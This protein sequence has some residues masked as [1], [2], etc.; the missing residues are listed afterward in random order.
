[1]TEPSPARAI[2]DATP[3]AVAWL[4]A[5]AGADRARISGLLHPD[6]VLIDA[7]TQYVNGAESVLRRLRADDVFH[8]AQVRIGDLHHAEN[9]MNGD[10]L[11]VA[12]VHLHLPVSADA[13]AEYRLV[14]ALS[15][16]AGVVRRIVI[17]SENL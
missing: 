6:V 14:M 5:L 8:G 1:M 12:E 16:D 15:A 7:N 10:T 4:N 3:P 2:R 17:D 13:T 9:S 11:T